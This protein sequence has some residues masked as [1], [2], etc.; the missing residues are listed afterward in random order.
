MFVFDGIRMINRKEYYARRKINNAKY[1]EARKFACALK[2]I[3]NF[4]STFFW[5]V[6]SYKIVS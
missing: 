6:V 3:N 2:I 5:L 4:T 1:L